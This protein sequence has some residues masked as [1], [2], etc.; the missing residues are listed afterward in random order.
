ML[1]LPRLSL[2]AAMSLLIT[3]AHAQS[4]RMNFDDLPD[5]GGIWQRLGTAVFDPATAEGQGQSGSPG[6]RQY[7]PYT[8]EWERKYEANM[9]LRDQGIFPDPI[10]ICGTPAGFPRLLNLPDVYEFGISRDKVWIISENGPNIMRIY[11]DG[12]DH[13]PPEDRWPTYTGD[14][15]GHWEGDILVFDTLSL[16]SSEEGRTILDRSG[17]TLSEAA[18][19]FTRMGQIDENTIEIQMT[20]H[21]EI[22][23]TEPWVVTKQYGR[24]PADTLMYDYACAENNRNPVDPNTGKT[25]TLDTEGQ[26]IDLDVE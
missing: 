3:P 7:P 24:L 11:T 8:E 26:V 14:S 4:E 12:R 1:L 19:I 21:D 22:A 18:H 6:V 5:W 13:P 17:A 9:A 10:S 20:I 2:F 15:V 16:L 23:L 25:L